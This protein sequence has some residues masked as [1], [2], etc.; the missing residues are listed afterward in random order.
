[1]YQCPHA[2][3]VAVKR[4]CPTG[5]VYG[6]GLSAGLVAS[7]DGALGA[8]HAEHGFQLDVSDLQLDQLV[9]QIR[10]GFESFGT[11]CHH[12]GVFASLRPRFD[13]S[14]ATRSCQLSSTS[15]ATLTS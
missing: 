15:L 4:L 2:V 9:Q 13:S 12:V 14:V 3:G 6:V 5:R 7:D 1:M 11:S 8:Q 10:P